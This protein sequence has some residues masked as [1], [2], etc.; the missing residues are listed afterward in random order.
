MCRKI[1][2]FL[3]FFFIISDFVFAQEAPSKKDSTKLYRDIENFSKKRKTTNFLYR[4][5]FRPV[6]LPADQTI[7]SKKKTKLPK[8][9]SSFEG[10]IIRQIYI[11]TLDPYG[12]SVTDTT[13]Q[14]QNILSK[15]GNGTHIK[16][17]PFTIRNLLLI[18]K[19]EPFDSLLVKESERLIR[20]QSY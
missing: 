11:T 5:F 12:Y 19:N 9:Y 15:A 17:L 13:T 8:P 4:F 16:S 7:K 18:H 20:S 2:L 14:T 3:F 1:F 6:P 10:K